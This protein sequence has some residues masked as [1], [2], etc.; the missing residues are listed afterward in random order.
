MCSK[1]KAK[2]LTLWCQCVFHLVGRIGILV[3]NGCPLTM[4]RM[5][6]HTSE[7]RQ[8]CYLNIGPSR[9]LDLAG[10]SFP[11]EQSEGGRR[12]TEEEE[13]SRE[14]F[15]FMSQWAVL[16]QS[17]YMTLS[18]MISIGILLHTTFAYDAIWC[19]QV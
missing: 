12:E 1:I 3:C 14:T 9:S 6:W 13:R 2:V 18:N 17:V 15:L 5:Y 4:L 16:G 10:F 11:Q 7:G 8:P 19:A